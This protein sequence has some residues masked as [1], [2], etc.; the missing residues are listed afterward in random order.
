MWGWHSLT[1]WMGIPRCTHP[2]TYRKGAVCM[3]TLT[4][5]KNSK[6]YV[7]FLRQFANL[8]RFS[9]NGTLSFSEYKRVHDRLADTLRPGMSQ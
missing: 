1:I 4:S 5:R 6:T 8:Y 9:A 7:L 2:K 3:M